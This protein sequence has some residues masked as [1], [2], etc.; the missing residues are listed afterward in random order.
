MARRGAVMPF[1]GVGTA[2]APR[3]SRNAAEAEM[4]NWTSKAAPA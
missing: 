1:I 2:G 4:L 3:A